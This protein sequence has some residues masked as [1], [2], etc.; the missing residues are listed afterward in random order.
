M[1][2]RKRKDYNDAGWEIV[3]GNYERF[4]QQK[5]AD[6]TSV[7]WWHVGPKMHIYGRFARGFEHKS[8]KM[9]MYFRFQDGFFISSAKKIEVRVVYLD[10]G[11]GKWS[12]LYYN[13][14]KEAVAYTVQCGGSGKWKEKT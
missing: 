13:G 8:N 2:N 14:K 10:Q 9:A 1:K 7:G 4:I 5:D 12:L 11:K 6:K 3:R